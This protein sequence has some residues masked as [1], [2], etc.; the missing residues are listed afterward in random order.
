ME[1]A[2]SLFCSV[3]VSLTAWMG[4]MKLAAVRAITPQSFPLSFL[5]VWLQQSNLTKPDQAKVQ[6]ICDG[7]IHLSSLSVVSC[8]GS[9]GLKPLETKLFCYSV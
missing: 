8:L 1:V 7:K 6:F 2:S 5:F 3:M 4:L 9:S